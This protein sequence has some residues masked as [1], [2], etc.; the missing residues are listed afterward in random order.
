[1]TSKKSCPN[2]GIEHISSAR[3]IPPFVPSDA[4]PRDLIYF[5]LM[6]NAIYCIYH[7]YIIIVHRIEIMGILKLLESYKW[8]RL[9]MGINPKRIAFKMEDSILLVLCVSLVDS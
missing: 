3:M 6:M 8:K 9:L 5:W 2:A 4:P 1:M 7:R